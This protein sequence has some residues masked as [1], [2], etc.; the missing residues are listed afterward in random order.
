MAITPG[1][2]VGPYQILSAIARGRSFD[3]VSQLAV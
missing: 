3:G 1:K 2:T